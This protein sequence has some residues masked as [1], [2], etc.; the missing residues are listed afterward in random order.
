[1]TL[2]RM[3]VAT[4][5]LIAACVLLKLL[6]TALEPS[7][8]F[9]PMAGEVENPSAEGINYH[10]LELS[11]TDGERLV[12]WQLEPEDSSA[13]VVYFHGNGGNLSVW[14][15]VF[16]ALTHAKLRVLAVDYRGYGGSTGRPSEQG[17]YRDAEAVVTYA[18]RQRASGASRPL[19]YWGRSLGGAVAAAAARFAPPDGVILESTFA[20]K[21]AVIR[22]NPILRALNLFSSYRFATVDALRDFSGPVLV[23]HGD[24][25]SVIP[26]DLG[27]E[28]FDRLDAPKRF[29]VIRGGDHNDAFPVSDRAY[30]EPVL[31]F[32]A[33]LSNTSSSPH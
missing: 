2:G 7:L 6:V 30:W 9:Y 27:R 3:L 11:T 4:L 21:A 17:L 5:V 24:R 26:F 13:D 12:A 29:A 25:D 14:L 19:V 32:V 15:P 31:E 16:A 10:R 18:R 8:V 33:S 23:M 22:R 28:L 1:M 20:D